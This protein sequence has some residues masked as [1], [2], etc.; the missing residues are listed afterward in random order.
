MTSKKTPA[1]PVVGQELFVVL[2]ALEY[3][4]PPSTRV[5][6]VAKVG[7]VW[8]EL[9]AHGLRAYRMALDTWR[10]DGQ[11]YI[12]PGRVYESE[13]AYLDEVT[14]T[15]AWKNLQNQMGAFPVRPAPAATLEVIQ[16]VT[17]L[18]GFLEESQP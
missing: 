4:H 11:G 15:N 8:A 16:Q 1:K 3:G 13:K 9:E 12:S 14:L 5:M 7:R 18:L 10:L 6:R 17:R 2:P